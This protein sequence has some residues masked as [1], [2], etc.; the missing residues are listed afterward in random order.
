M[1]SATGFVFFDVSAFHTPPPLA[2]IH[3]RLLDAGGDPT[4]SKSAKCNASSQMYLT[5]SE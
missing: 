2:Q 3:R 1:R 4:S 5:L